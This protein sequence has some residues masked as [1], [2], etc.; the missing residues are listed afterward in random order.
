VG[1][2]KDFVVPAIP[3]AVS[4]SYGGLGFDQTASGFIRDAFEISLLD[5][6]GNSLVQSIESERAS[7][8]NATEGLPN[9]IAS[10]IRIENGTITVGL[11]G[12]TPG[13]KAKLVARLVNE[14]RDTSSQVVLTDFRIA[15][16]NLAA[17]PAGGASSQSQRSSPTETST[18]T[19][20]PQAKIGANLL[21]N[22]GKAT[23]TNS[24]GIGIGIEN[25][26]VNGTANSTPQS[27]RFIPISTPFNLPIGIDYH[28]PTNSVVVSVNYSSGNP[29]SFE[30]IDRDG[31]HTPF[32]NVRGLGDEVKIATVRLGNVGGF[33]AGDMFSGNGIDGEILKIGGD[34]LIVD[35]PWISLPGN[36]NGLMRGS[37]YVDRTGDFGGDLIAVTTSGEVWRINSA[38]VPTLLA[39]IGTHLEGVITVPNHPD[40][41][42]PLAGK[43]I[44]GAEDQG[45]LYAIDASGAVSSYSLG[46]NIEDI[47]LVPPGE[48]FFGVNF[49]TGRILGAPA[50]SFKSMVGDI[51]LT[52]EFHGGSGLYRLFW[53]GTVLKTEQLGLA[54]D[55]AAVGQWEHLTF[56]PSGIS[57]LDEV[58]Q[59]PTIFV[60]ASVH[61]ANVGE[62][63]LL[64]GIA[65]AFGN[66]A[67][68]VKNRISY[69][70]V[71]GK[72]IDV[73]DNSASFFQSEVVGPGLNRFVFEATDDI[74][75]T[76]TAELSIEGLNKEPGDVDFRNYVDLTSAYTGLYSR[77]SFNDGS[78]E[79]LVNLA[80]RNDGTF[81]SDVP[82]LVGVK[83]VSDPT[84]S[85]IDFDGLTPDGI[86]YFDYS[87]HVPGGTLAPGATTGSPSIAFHNPKSIRFDYELEFYG[88][89]N[90][91]P[92]IT[93]LPDIEA[94]TVKQYVY[95]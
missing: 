26:N 58:P 3:S 10:G 25:G 13:T 67:P 73:F 33:A 45:L 36:G 75:Q 38:A 24:S 14:D 88:K 32:S 46:V 57:E 23:G 82:L 95:P 71:N 19:V 76:V 22:V 90:T 92:Q 55:T 29:I 64:S 69:V 63:V 78:K 87:Q 17:V 47:E 6:F 65:E 62:R 41:Y 54:S 52:Q 7:I 94:L 43:I 91:P 4:L 27:I 18:V 2:S 48:N 5:E 31:N 81:V 11:G 60:S 8:F 35:N 49:G 70:F 86:P 21:P 61:S 89:Q 68:N 40:R 15:A 34:G 51:L 93:S 56:S 83:N 85:V 84:V 74:G 9:A 28:A 1:L 50:A 77:T 44:A 39:R 79:L 66:S 12:I 59:P 20:V 30:R 53:D 80:T 42:G 37:L 72:P 16:S